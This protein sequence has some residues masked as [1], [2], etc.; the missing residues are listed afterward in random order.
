MHYNNATTAQLCLKLN[1]KHRLCWRMCWP[2]EFSSLSPPILTLLATAIS[3]AGVAVNTRG[4]WRHHGVQ[5]T[6]PRPQA[7]RTAGCYAT[8]GRDPTP[9]HTAGTQHSTMTHPPESGYDVW[10][11][12]Q[13]IC[14]RFPG[15]NLVGRTNLRAR[16]GDGIPVLLWTRGW[17][18]VLRGIKWEQKQDLMALEFLVDEVVIS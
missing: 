18:L 7:T 3:A 9:T 1:Y 5:C 14:S 13:S 15:E 4:L 16:L 11:G 8:T 17:M 6:D 10:A 2:N 12:L